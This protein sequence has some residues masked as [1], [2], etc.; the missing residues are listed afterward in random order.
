MIYPPF[1]E[2]YVFTGPDTAISCSVDYDRE[3]ECYIATSGEGFYGAADSPDGAA[4]AC[5][6]AWMTNT[7]GW[8]VPR[9]EEER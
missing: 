1:T 9:G 5:F 3:Q 2:R 4:L 7:R 6:T 8:Y